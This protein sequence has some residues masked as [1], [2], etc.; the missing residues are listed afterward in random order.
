MMITNISS[1]Y[2]INY[3]IQIPQLT[4]KPSFPH[5]PTQF[6]LPKIPNLDRKAS[7]CSQ[8]NPVFL[9]SGRV[10]GHDFLVLSRFVTLVQDKLVKKWSFWSHPGIIFG[11]FEKNGYTWTSLRP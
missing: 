1:L 8:E 9:I 10:R 11:M 3:D 5:T 6:E 7:N 4:G 2:S